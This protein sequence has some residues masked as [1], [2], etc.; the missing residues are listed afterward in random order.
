MSLDQFSQ[1]E[2]NHPKLLAFQHKIANLGG[3]LSNS[4]IAEFII[5]NIRK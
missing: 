4:I 3:F 5:K 1:E 2:L